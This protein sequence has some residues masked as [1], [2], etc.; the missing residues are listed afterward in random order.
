V[1]FVVGHLHEV[2]RASEAGVVDHHVDSPVAIGGGGEQFLD[3]HLVG[4]VAGD[5]Q[6]R[7]GTGRGGHG[8]DLG[9]LGQL[10]RR[11]AE[12]PFVG[13]ADHH[14]GALEQQTPRRGRPDPRAR[15][16]GDDGDLACQQAVPGRLGWR[17]GR[18]R[19]ALARHRTPPGPGQ[20]RTVTRAGG[21]GERSA[22]V[23][24]STFRQRQ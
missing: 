23:I 18:R 22:F 3:L 15:G 11:L 12:P 1:P 16:G 4:H 7:F 13:V 6:R 20:W 14:R 10:G 19:A 17:R 9:Q 5:R 24:A 2:G 21:N 8:P